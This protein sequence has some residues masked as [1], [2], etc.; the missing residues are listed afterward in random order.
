MRRIITIVFFIS[1]LSVNSISQTLKPV[2]NY[3]INLDTINF[4]GFNVE[5]NIDNS[6]D[7]LLLA[8]AVHPEYDEQFWKNLKSIVV[9]TGGEKVRAVKLDSSLWRISVKNKKAIVKYSFEVKTQLNSIRRCWRIFLRDTGGLIGGNQTFLYPVNYEDIPSSITLS[10]PSGWEIATGLEQTKQPNIFHAKNFDELVDSPFLIGKMHYWKFYVDNIPHIIAYWALPEFKP[11]DTV[12]FVKIVESI[13]NSA[14]SMF[15]HPP[16]KKYFFLFQDGAGDALEHLNSL[17][18]GT[19][20][21]MLSENIHSYDNELAH[22][23][24]HTWNLV[25]IRP[26]EQSLISYKPTIPTASLW[27]SEGVTIYFAN[28]ILRRA[29]LIDST[30]L[31]R[32]L[33][34]NITAYFQNPGNVRISPEDASLGTNS[35]LK[36]DSGYSA[37]YYTQGQLFGQVLNIIIRDSTNMKSGLEDVMRAMLEKYPREKGFTTSDIEE[38]ANKVC[39]CNLHSFFEKYI[40]TADPLDINLYLQSIGMKAVMSYETA[41]D[42]NGNELPDLHVFG[43]IPEGSDKVRILIYY[44]PNVWWYSGLRTGDY[45]NEMNDEKIVSLEDFRKILSSQV[46]G[47]SLKISYLREGK[48][49]ETSLIITGY[50]K[51]NV[52]LEEII[53]PTPHQLMMRKLWLEGKL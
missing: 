32:R 22:E 9:E 7:T 37:S 51:V 20:S 44:T 35:K 43:L 10:L 42:S 16:Y 21:K 12:A 47:N 6:P 5:M 26:R 18:L 45:I 29:G 15:G 31:L 19:S 13:V 28:I 11:F 36:S 49:F 17:T 8:F 14:V 4:S 2:I 34:N 24:F 53:S 46:I 48:N 23:F 41:L 40:H 52:K 33:N 38:T 27:F 3:K 25:R 50:K 1:Y 30:E 39:G